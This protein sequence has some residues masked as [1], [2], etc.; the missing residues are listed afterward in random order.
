MDFH[1]HNQVPLPGQHAHTT[2]ASSNKRSA[3]SGFAL[4][5]IKIRKLLEVERILGYMGTPFA[6]ADMT[7]YVKYAGSE[8]RW[9][10]FAQDLAETDAFRRFLDE[11][12]EL[13]PLKHSPIEARALVNSKAKRQFPT[14]LLGQTVYIPLQAY[15]FNDDGLNG[16]YEASG[17]PELHS[18]RYFVAAKLDSKLDPSAKG[19]NS[20]WLKADIWPSKSNWIHADSVYLERY[21]YE[22][23]PLN[24]VLVNPGFAKFYPNLEAQIVEDEDD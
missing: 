10:G 24:A 20:A 3:A 21:V 7:F 12:K 14:H 11:T 16:W 15:S 23:I 2:A 6:R 9:R 1:S 22:V 19:K 5:K 17:L 8:P 13:W 4:P 18:A